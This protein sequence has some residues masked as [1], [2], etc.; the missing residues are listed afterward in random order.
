[1]NQKLKRNLMTYGTSFLLGGGL[2]YLYIRLRDFPV[3][4]ASENYKMLSDAA[5]VPGVLLVMLGTLIWV[6]KQGALD[7]VSYGVSR[8]FRGLIP[9]GRLQ[10]DEK[11][12]DYVERRREKAKQTRGYAFLFISGLVFLAIA[13]VFIV[14]YYTAL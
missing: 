1:M 6:S 11:Y 8:L 7:G 14:L 4:E 5:A 10:K 2:F 12:F 9:G 13:G 3:E